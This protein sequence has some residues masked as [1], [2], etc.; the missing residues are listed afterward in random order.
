MNTVAR[1]ALERTPSKTLNLSACHKL[2]RSLAVTVFALNALIAGAAVAESSVCQKPDIRTAER[3]API[4]TPTVITASFIIADVLAVNDVDQRIELD[5]IATFEWKDA[6]LS[7]LAGCQF[8][9]SDVWFPRLSLLDSSALDMERKNTQ[10]RVQI[11]EEGAVFYRQRYSGTISTYHNLRRFPFDN[12]SF[13][14]G[15]VTLSD[16]R[17]A[18]QFVANNDQTTISDTLNIE[19]WTIEGVE[20][21]SVDRHVPQVGLDLSVLTLRILA[22]RDADFFIYR[23]LLPLFLVVAMSWAVFWVPP[24]RF[25][26]QIGLG[27]TSMLTVIAFNLTIGNNLPALGYLTALDAMIIWAIL[28]VFLSIVEA[29]CAGLWQQKGYSERAHTLDLVSR[30]AFPFSLIAGWLFLVM[31]W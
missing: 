22:N 26:F 27:A 19:G 13:E 3:P 10:N 5:L 16:D 31:F 20:L 17:N 2:R 25:E 11:G 15:I 29:L 1:R 9:V 6:R 23:V 24:E 12:H 7:G 4:N 18:I 28:L 14:I 30:F 8:Q 21:F